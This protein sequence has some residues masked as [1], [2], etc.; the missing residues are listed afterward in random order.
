[1]GDLMTIVSLRRKYP[2]LVKRA[3]KSCR[4]RFEKRPTLK[5]GRGY[6]RNETWRSKRNGTVKRARVTVSRRMAKE[7]PKLAQLCILHELRSNLLLQNGYS[8]SRAR[9]RATRMERGD[10][11]RLGFNGRKK[12]K[13]LLW[14]FYLGR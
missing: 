4:L 7:D 2:S 13:W 5:L 3:E 10:M 6:P 9:K 8:P 11:K 14:N 1:M 12:A